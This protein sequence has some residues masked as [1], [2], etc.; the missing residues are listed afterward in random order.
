MNASLH[1]IIP[2]AIL[3]LV[4][5]I[6]ILC[7]K[8]DFLISGYNTASAEEKAQY[9]IHRLRLVT[10]IAMII[11]AAT[12]TITALFEGGEKWVIPIIIPTAI[13]VLVFSNIWAKN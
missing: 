5:A 9:N 7:G 3:C 12:I 2:V 10:G 13:G 1:V 6:A 11:V 8:G 4:G